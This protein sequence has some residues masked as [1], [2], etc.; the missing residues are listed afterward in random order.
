MAFKAKALLSALLLAATSVHAQAQSK[1]Q[2]DLDSTG[3]HSPSG[4]FLVG[5][6]GDDR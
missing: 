1:L 3:E 2:V 6:A 5:V 4:L